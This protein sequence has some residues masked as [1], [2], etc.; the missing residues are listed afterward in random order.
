MLCV[1]VWQ[2]LGWVHV[3]HTG[4]AQQSFLHAF[5]FCLLAIV[6]DLRVVYEVQ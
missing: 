6:M 4:V 1:S 5:F 3:V 2:P